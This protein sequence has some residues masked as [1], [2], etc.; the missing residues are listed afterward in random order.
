MGWLPAAAVTCGF[1]L[2]VVFL[3]EPLLSTNE[4]LLW[5]GQDARIPR[6]DES[7]GYRRADRRNPGEPALENDLSKNL[8]E[9]NMLPPQNQSLYPRLKD[10]HVKLV[11]YV[12]NR[13]EYLRVVVV[14]LSGVEGIEETLLIVSHD[15]FFEEINSICA[16]HAILPSSCSSS[17]SKMLGLHS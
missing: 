4:F 5:V 2:V 10:E 1:S 7:N 3:L 9:Q 13:P 12:H 11:L 16:G 14:G 6:V 17:I 8:M 15:G